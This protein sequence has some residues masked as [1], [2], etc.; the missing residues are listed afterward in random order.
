MIARFPTMLAT[1]RSAI[2]TGSQSCIIPVNS[3]CIRVLELFRSHGLIQGFS[4]VY[5]NRKKTTQ[6][7]PS[8]R[9]LI[10]FK[11]VDNN[12]SVLKDIKNSKNTRSNFVTL[13]HLKGNALRLNTHSLFIISN[14]TGIRLT[15]LQGLAENRQDSKIKNTNGKVLGE[16]RL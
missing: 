1:M 11:Y 6:V 10:I 9:A 4:F 5:V 8:P 16:I 14:S 2:K 13:K 12:T 7:Y 15:S 3:L